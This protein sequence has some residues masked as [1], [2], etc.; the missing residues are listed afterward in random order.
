MKKILVPA[1]ILPALAQIAPATTVL[2]TDDFTVS[3]NVNNPNFE[4]GN[5]R[6]GGSLALPTLSYIERFPGTGSQEQVGNATTFTGNANALLLAFG[7]GVVIDYNFATIATPIE[8]SFD[9]VLS[10]GNSPLITNWVSVNI[11]NNTFQSN[12]VTDADFGILFRANGDTELFNSAILPGDRTGI[13]GTNTGF[14]VFST[15]RVILSDTAGTGSAFAGNGST[16]SYYEGD[17]LLETRQLSQL[18]GGYIG[19][20]ANSIG[21]ID[22]LQIISI[23]EASSMLLGCLGAAGLLRR[24]RV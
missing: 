24:R 19:F 21:G 17:R 5:G 1:L 6:Q 22:N 9:R 16:V 18:T 4:L 13:S 2:L 8:I 14:D 7:G 20:G 15:Y 10:N 3:A 12:F 11:L 23:P